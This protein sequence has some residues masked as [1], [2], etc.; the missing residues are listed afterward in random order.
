MEKIQI[1]KTLEDI[2]KDV[3]EE[4]NLIITEDMEVSDINGWDSLSQINIID[5]IEKRFN[6]HFSIGEIVVLKTIDDIIKLIETKL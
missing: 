5:E 6:I 4:E 2:F 3:L 1:I